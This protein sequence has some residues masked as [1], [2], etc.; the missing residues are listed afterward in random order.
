MRRK[1]S[2]LFLGILLGCIA[3]GQAQSR[4]WAFSRDTV[5]QMY[6]GPG[7]DTVRVTNSGTDTLR[8]D[9]VHLELVRPTA[10]QYKAVFYPV[11]RTAQNQ[12]YVVSYDTGVVSYAFLNFP[13]VRSIRIKAQDSARFSGFMVGRNPLVVTKRSAI[14][15]EDTVAVRMIFIASGGRGRDTLTVIGRENMV[16]AIKPKSEK[17]RGSES[18]S[19]RFDLRGRRVEEMPEGQR[20]PRTSVNSTKDLS[21]L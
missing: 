18:R 17:T 16:I 15:P 3:F 10:T 14:D 21:G 19:D 8:F 13:D 6:A 5:C 7:T 4:T 20:I 11:A 12:P 1:T 9:S 2:L